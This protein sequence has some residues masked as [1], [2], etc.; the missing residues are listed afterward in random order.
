MRT[1][2]TTLRAVLTQM[3][4]WEGQTGSSPQKILPRKSSEHREQ[5]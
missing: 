5:E 3:G 2:E 1:G 4:V